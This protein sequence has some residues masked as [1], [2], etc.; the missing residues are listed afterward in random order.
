MHGA[1]ERVERAAGRV[2][3]GAGLA[4]IFRAWPASRSGLRDAMPSSHVRLAL[5]AIACMGVAVA[6][7]TA[8]LLVHAEEDRAATKLNIR[9]A[10]INNARA[11]DR[12]VAVTEALLVG[13]RASPSL[14]SGDWAA[15]YEQA[16]ELAAPRGSRV[17]VYGLNS[18]GKREIL[19]N[20]GLPFGAPV[21]PTVPST[22]RIVETFI[23]KIFATRQPVVSDVNISR[24]DGQPITGV[25]I[26]VMEGLDVRYA[27]VAVIPAL[28]DSPIF[29]SSNL[30]A[31]WFSGVVDREGRYVAGHRSPARAAN[32]PVI[33]AA[34]RKAMAADQNIF[35]GVTGDGRVLYVSQ[36]RSSKTGWN[37]I[38]AVPRQTFEGS[39]Y[40]VLVIAA[41]TGSLLILAAF[42]VGLVAEPRVTRPLRERLIEDEERFR[43]MANTVPS[44]LF[45][46]DPIGRCD[47]VSDAFYAYTGLS[48]RAADGLGWVDAF[49]PEDRQRVLDMLDSMPAAPCPPDAAARADTKRGTLLDV[50]ASDVEARLRA[51]NGAYRWFLIRVCFLAGANG[52]QSKRFGTATDIDEIKQTARAFRHSEREMRRLSAQLMRSQDDERR[53]IAREIHDTTLQDLVGAMILMDQIRAGPS[54]SSEETFDEIRDLITRSLQDLR[55]LSYLLHPTLLDAI[56]LPPAVKWYARGFEK[57]SGIRVTVQA[58]EGMPRLSEDVEIALFRVVQEG[59]ANVYRHSGSDEARIVLEHNGQSVALEIIDRGKGIG[60]V[61]GAQAATD[62]V[63]LGVG[64]PG[65]RLRLQQIGGTLEIDTSPRGTTVRATVA[66][67][68]GTGAKGS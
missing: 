58:P 68:R 26:P 12:E 49:H 28:D 32:L 35:D 6:A 5:F 60:S 39:W 25:G 3:F 40:R 33:D 67:D 20:T 51:R 47:Y 37:S 14:R 27:L 55:T 23:G 41:A 34:F 16:K 38:V 62:D 36:S 54:A 30:P 8:L 29:G 59:L 17:L 15:F 65:M 24:L 19:L 43:M 63:T 31:G 4:R 66:L 46:T 21:P 11:V 64:I 45:T 56:G 9:A 48:D 13:L 10:A 61:L 22:D 7:F 2:F 50:G 52:R 57:R 44:I 42:G 18:Q 1:G 53:R